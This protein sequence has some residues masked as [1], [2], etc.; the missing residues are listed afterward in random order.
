MLPNGDV[1]CRAIF[2]SKMLSKAVDTL[3]GH[4]LSIRTASAAADVL[5]KVHVVSHEEDSVC[6]TPGVGD[7]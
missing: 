5:L 2:L 6:N 3:T 7:L 4:V 1:Q